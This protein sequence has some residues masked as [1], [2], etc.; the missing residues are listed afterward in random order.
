MNPQNSK[1]TFSEILAKSNNTPP[2]LKEPELPVEEKTEDES[3]AT[4]DEDYHLFHSKLLNNIHENLKHY[5]NF[6]KLSLIQKLSEYEIEE[7]LV[8]ITDK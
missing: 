4:S 7:F 6:S 2:P 8:K 3:D 5:V 1:K